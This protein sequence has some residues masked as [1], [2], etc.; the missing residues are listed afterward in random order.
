[1]GQRNMYSRV[2]VLYDG[3]E[4]HDLKQKN[5]KSLL[6]IRIKTMS[7]VVFLFFSFLFFFVQDGSCLKC[8]RHLIGF[9]QL[10]IRYRYSDVTVYAREI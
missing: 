8:P 7:E 2:S 4:R 3:T 1:M 5:S 10:I 6:E 9:L